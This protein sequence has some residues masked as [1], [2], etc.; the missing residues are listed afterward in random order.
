MKFFALRSAS[1]STR[2]AEF[3]GRTSRVAGGLM[4]A[5]AGFLAIAPAALLA[6]S[7]DDDVPTSTAKTGAATTPQ[8]QRSIRLS[9]A[10]GSVRVALDGQIVAEPAV[11]NMPLFEGTEIATGSDGRAELQFEDG[12]LARLSPNTVVVLS[13]LQQQGSD[14]RS[15]VVMQSGLTYFELQP[16]TAEHSLKVNYGTAAFSASSFSVVRVLRDQ[17]PGNVAVFSGN[18]RLEQGASQEL[19]LHGGESVNVDTNDFS[20]STVAESI[21]PDSWDSWNADR[22]ASLSGE[23][24]QRTTASNSLGNYPAAG[25]ADLDANGN[26]YNVPGQ[27]YLWSPYDAQGQGAGWDP[28]G[29]GQWVYYP[30]RGYVWVSGYAWGYSPFQCGLWNYYDSF[31]WGWAPGAGCTPWYEFGEGYYG[32]GGGYYNIGL[33]PRGYLPPKRPLPG[34]IHPRGGPHP[35]QG[36][37]GLASHTLIA[38]APIVPV[39][40]R[41]P[42]TA[43]PVRSTEP[44]MIAGHLVQPLRPVAPRQT[45]QRAG[46]FSSGSSFVRTDPAATFNPYVNGYPRTGSGAGSGGSGARPGS[47]TGQRPGGYSGSGSAGS[48]PAPSHTASSG[49]GGHAASGGGGGGSHGGGGGGGGTHK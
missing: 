22:D 2:Q 19:D 30:G 14:T 33:H 40:R 32:G 39:D 4:L 43:N 5:L 48:H 27:G 37:G 6:K 12:S 29:Y 1:L 28:Y 9:F 45:Y 24:S 15:E 23:T 44:V 20:L 13:V 16:S 7:A 36:K 8:D 42:V 10:E 46:S 35:G 41:Q 49:G 34:P 38:G 26:W 11:S 21:E 17:P 25:L 31:G 47:G 3:R 18:V